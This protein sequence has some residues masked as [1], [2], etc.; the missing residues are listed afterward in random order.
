[1][2]SHQASKRTSEEVT[3]NGHRIHVLEQSFMEESVAEPVISAPL[4]GK[5]G[6][7]NQQSII[8][9]N[10]TDTQVLGPFPSKTAPVPELPPKIPDETE[11]NFLPKSVPPAEVY[12]PVADEALDDETTLEDEERNAAADVDELD[13]LGRLGEMPL[14]ELLRMYGAATQGNVTESLNIGISQEIIRNEQLP[15]MSAIPFV[16]NSDFGGPSQS[17]SSSS[18]EQCGNDGEE[19]CSTDGEEEYTANE[20]KNIQ[21]SIDLMKFLASVGAKGREQTEGSDTDD[22]STDEEFVPVHLLMLRPRETPIGAMHQVDLPERDSL[23]ADN[24]SDPSDQVLSWAPRVPEEFVRSK[25]L[26]N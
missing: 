14:E 9:H 16:F 23:Y 11:E 17:S 19:W 12:E 20:E 7:T 8:L 15:P 22:S 2:D 26:W 10:V 4:S 5:I 1:M 25:L 18:G 6:L 3:E 21:G 13:E 24:T